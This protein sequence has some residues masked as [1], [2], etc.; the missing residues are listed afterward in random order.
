MVI[1]FV[2]CSWY[3]CFTV[4]VVSTKGAVVL[5]AALY[6]CAILVVDV[7]YAFTFMDTVPGRFVVRISW[8]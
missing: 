7:R 1:E 3:S 5:C 2:V 8:W 6:V 4:T